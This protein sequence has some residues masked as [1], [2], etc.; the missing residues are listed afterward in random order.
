MCNSFCWYQWQIFELTF[1]RHPSLCICLRRLGPSW[2]TPRPR[3]RPPASPQPLRRPTFC[4]R[5]AFWVGD[6]VV[7][8][9]LSLSLQ[10]MSFRSYCCSLFFYCNEL[11]VKLSLHIPQKGIKGSCTYFSH[12]YLLFPQKGFDYSLKSYRRFTSQ[13]FE[14]SIRTFYCC[15]NKLYQ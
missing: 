1:P 7:R 6:I 13:I 12:D 15:V 14:I 5:K 9:Q 2:W 10:K 4:Q 8:W 11:L 3:P